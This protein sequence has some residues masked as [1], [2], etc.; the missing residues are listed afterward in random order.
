M[1]II[2]KVN[3]Y[4]QFL[5]YILYISDKCPQIMKHLTTNDRFSPKLEKS[6]ALI[7]L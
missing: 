4:E 7:F 2:V 3:I 1:Q 6:G 5:L